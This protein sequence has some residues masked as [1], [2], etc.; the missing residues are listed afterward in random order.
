MALRVFKTFIGFSPHK[1]L[2]L[3]L[4]QQKRVFQQTWV[5]SK[6]TRAMTQIQG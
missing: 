5:K 2:S 1:R 6:T 4:T 3:V